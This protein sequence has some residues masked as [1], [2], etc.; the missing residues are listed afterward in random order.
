MAQISQMLRRGAWGD[1]LCIAAQSPRV[2]AV[3]VRPPP[4]SIR[5][6]CGICEKKHRAVTCPICCYVQIP[7]P[8][9][10]RHPR[11]L[12]QHPRPRP[13]RP[14]LS[15]A[16]I[17]MVSGAMETVQTGTL[18]KTIRRKF[19]FF[20]IYHY[21]CNRLFERCKA[22]RVIEEDRPPNPSPHSFGS[23]HSSQ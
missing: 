16:Q 18:T 3:I 13:F 20:P 21:L 10:T 17:P 1:G 2:C 9:P 22:L 23:P 8:Q 15:N 11:L 19:F 4:R 14:F 6:I 5:E 7:T 12:S